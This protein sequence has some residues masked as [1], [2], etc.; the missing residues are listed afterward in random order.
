MIGNKLRGTEKLV[1]VIVR[2]WKNLDF[3]WESRS[4]MAL[5][6]TGIEIKFDKLLGGTL[7]VDIHVTSRELAS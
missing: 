1:E 4:I 5:V 6:A 7:T 2:E 3:G